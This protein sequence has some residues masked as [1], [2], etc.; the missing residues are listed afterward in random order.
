MDLF[1]QWDRE[2]CIAKFNR[3]VLRS[4]EIS[5]QSQLAK[6]FDFKDPGNPNT[7]PEI[8]FIAEANEDV[9][10]SNCKLSN[11]DAQQTYTKYCLI[12]L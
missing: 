11:A 7:N 12:S 10:T 6:I 4:T 3:F 1:N 8:T 5:D 2:Y 9:V